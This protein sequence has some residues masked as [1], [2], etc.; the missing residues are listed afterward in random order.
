M[1]YL[2]DLRLEKARLG[3]Q[4]ADPRE[5]SVAMVAHSCGFRHMGRFSGSYRD[6]YGEYPGDTLRGRRRLV[7]A[8]DIV[9]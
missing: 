2:R 5:T 1:A 3:L 9:G 7:G 8:A 6:A 4:L